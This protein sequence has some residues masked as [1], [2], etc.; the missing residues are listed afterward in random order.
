MKK[1]WQKQAGPSTFDAQA[2]QEISLFLAPFYLCLLLGSQVSDVMTFA[3]ARGSDWCGRLFYLTS[4]LIDSL[5]FSLDTKYRLMVVSA[6][7]PTAILLTILA[8]VVANIVFSGQNGSVLPGETAAEINERLALAKT[9]NV[10]WPEELKWSTASATVVV[11]EQKLMDIT[12]K[13]KDLSPEQIAD[14]GQGELLNLALT[15][16]FLGDQDS[17]QIALQ[18]AR[19]MDPNDPVFADTAR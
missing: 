13:F 5:P 8:L 12:E 18:A 6:W 2:D 3:L 4:V 16:Y 9:V 15:R 17:Y 14:L 11:N 7:T 10:A 19:A 1:S